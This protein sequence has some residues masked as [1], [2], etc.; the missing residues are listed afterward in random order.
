MYK[1]EE[2]NEIWCLHCKEPIQPN[3]IYHTDENGNTFC[4]F[5]WKQLEEERNFNDE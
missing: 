2:F 3:E 4:D 1:E 5:C